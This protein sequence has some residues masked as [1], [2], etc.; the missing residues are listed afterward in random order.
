M[1]KR[2]IDFDAMWGSDKLA[3]CA[4]WAQ[5]EYAWLY[6]LADASGCFELTNLRVIWGRVAA[7]RRNLS[8]ER[9]EQVFCEF[10][11]KGLLFVW[12][13]EGKRYGHWTGSDVPG[14]LPAPSWRVRLE[15]LAPPVPKPTFTEYVSRF[16]RGRAALAGGGFSSEADGESR[17]REFET[18]DFKSANSL[19]EADRPDGDAQARTGPAGC[20]ESSA[21]VA[22]RGRAGAGRVSGGLPAGTRGRQVEPGHIA[23]TGMASGASGRSFRTEQDE[24]EL[25]LR[26]EAERAGEGTV[27]VPLKGDLESA[28][29]EDL[30]LNLNF[31]WDEKKEKREERREP[32][33]GSAGGQLTQVCS[34]LPT[35]LFSNSDSKPESERREHAADA[36]RTDANRDGR[37]AMAGAACSR[38]TFY[39]S[40]KSAALARELMVGRGPICG[41]VKVKPEALERMRMRDAARKGS[42]S[43]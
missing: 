14:R 5:A 13:H 17:K 36:K 24:T 21:S 12:E 28:Q 30:N 6:G 2:V 37:A 15:R 8:I 41:P 22:S 35:S 19:V 9:L 3:S 7:I 34:D 43:P 31:D 23:R 10:Q 27:C 1:P 11:N 4:E 29:A 18:S 25:K 38:P 40:E 20:G 39:S 32:R 26:S 42:R 33:H 16:A